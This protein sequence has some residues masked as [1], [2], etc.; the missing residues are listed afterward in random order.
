MGAVANL[1]LFLVLFHVGVL[2]AEPPTCYFQA[3]FNFGDSNSATGAT[4][5]SSPYGQTFFGK[6]SGRASDGRLIIDFM[7]ERLGLEYLNSYSES[8]GNNYRHGVNFAAG[9]ATIRPQSSNSNNIPSLNVQVGQFMEFKKQGSSHYGEDKYPQQSDF[10]N[11]LYTFDIGQNDLSAGV[12]SI[13]DIINQ[14]SQAINQLHDAG[15]RSFWIHNT[16]PMGCLPT[17]IYTSQSQDKDQFGC[18]KSENEVAKEFNR[19]L[20]DKV[21]EL[22]N[23][24]QDSALTYV[25][26]YSAKYNLISQAQQQGFNEP[27]KFCCGNYQ[28][29]GETVRCG[30]GS[31]TCQDPS[32]YVS[33]DAA[34]Y[35][36]AANKWVADRILNGD[37]SDTGS[38]IYQACFRQPYKH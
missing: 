36:E 7:D 20:K 12:G 2:L 4:Y 35:T 1:V 9:G 16:G 17:H 25:D 21:T 24:L 28:E 32:K 38:S 19:Q 6:P 3:I 26:V 29:G 27:T 8:A 33:W 15:A 30:Q 13:P 14:F 22:R 11:A 10:T 31:S 34:H 5:L 18:V 23:N 37:L